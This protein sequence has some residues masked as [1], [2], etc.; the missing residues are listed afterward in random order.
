MY[1]NILSLEPVHMPSYYKLFLNISVF[2]FLSRA[3]FTSIP[4][5]SQADL[6]WNTFQLKKP[7]A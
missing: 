3:S 2:I 5:F 6:G 7:D 4:S 1:I